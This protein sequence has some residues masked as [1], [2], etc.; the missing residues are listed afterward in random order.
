MWTRVGDCRARQ[1][2]KTRINWV[3]GTTTKH[4]C[5]LAS[6]KDDPLT[7]QLGK[8]S[9]PRWTQTCLSDSG[10]QARAFNQPGKHGLNPLNWMGGVNRDSSVTQQCLT[11]RMPTVCVGYRICYLVEGHRLWHTD[12]V[13]Y[14][15]YNSLHVDLSS[16]AWITSVPKPTKKA[17][18]P[19][20]K[21]DKFTGD[22][23][24]WSQNCNA[25][26]VKTNPRLAEEG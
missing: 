14:N 12:P 18:E 17:I 26:A 15:V 23:I 5:A 8:C 6:R 1:N 7:F 24:K 13:Q 4:C 3:I 21:S 22:I 19:Y 25:A 16:L 2:A 20:I 11:W 9:A 10:W